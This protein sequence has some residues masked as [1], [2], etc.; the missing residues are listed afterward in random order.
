VLQIGADG[1]PLP[2]PLVER[3][4]TWRFDAPAGVQAL[5]ERRIGRNELDTIEV[6]RAIGDAQAEYAASAG[7]SGAFQAYARRFI[8]SPGRQDGLYW[9]TEEGA[10]QSPLGPLA[11][12]ASAGGY[13]RG[14]GPQPYHGYLFRMLE[15]QGPNAPG[16]A[17]SYVVRDRMIG[18]FAV[19]AWPARWGST[20]ITSFITSHH[21]AVWQANLGPNTAARAAAIQ[22]FDPGPGWTR[23]PG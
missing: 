13:R 16:G 10:P 1:W 21:G 8:S 20:G 15:G 3:G 23:V 18:G 19:L 22:V 14:E 17:L 9:P 5:V 6:L 2:I 4:G 7:R 12:E 11:A